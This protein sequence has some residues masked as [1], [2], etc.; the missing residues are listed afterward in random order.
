MSGI[1]T[2]VGS[3]P[4]YIATATVPALTTIFTPPA[5][6]SNR[7]LA[8]EQTGIAWS[9]YSRDGYQPPVD[10]IYYSCLPERLRGPHYSPGVCTDGQT[11]ADITKYEAG[12][13]TMWQAQCCKRCA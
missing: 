11:I 5:S 3:L 6:C 2:T 8:A 12:T 9:T 4:Q 7:W 1:T 10:P 13:R